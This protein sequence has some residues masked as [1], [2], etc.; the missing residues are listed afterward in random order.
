MKIRPV[1]WCLWRIAVYQASIFDALL[2][3]THLIYHAYWIFCAKCYICVVFFVWFLC[4][5]YK[6]YRQFY[7]VF[8]QFLV[9]VKCLDNPFFTMCH[10]ANQKNPP[11]NFFRTTQYLTDSPPKIFGSEDSETFGWHITQNFQRCH[12]ATLEQCISLKYI[13]ISGTSKVPSICGAHPN[14]KPFARFNKTSQPYTDNV[15]P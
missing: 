9:V 13:L 4:N 7:W 11:I 10:I 8:V 6:I 5:I 2:Y 14:P 12:F 3:L 1:S 15:Y